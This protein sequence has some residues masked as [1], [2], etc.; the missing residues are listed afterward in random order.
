MVKIFSDKELLSQKD[1]SFFSGKNFD[2]VCMLSDDFVEI[3]RINNICRSNGVLFLSGFG[4]G[5]Y[6]YM[7]VDFN[8]FQYIV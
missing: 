4:F 3:S 7:F 1:S 8:S 2:L 6:G 5:L